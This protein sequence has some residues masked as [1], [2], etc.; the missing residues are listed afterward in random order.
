MLKLLKLSSDFSN[1]YNKF[2]NIKINQNE[3]EFCSTMKKVYFNLVN[4]KELNFMYNYIFKNGNFIIP[5]KVK[6]FIDEIKKN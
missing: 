1:I 2:N 3:S 6:N 4:I 5:D